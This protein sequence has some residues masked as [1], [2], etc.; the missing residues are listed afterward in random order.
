ML[1]GIPAWALATGAGFYMTKQFFFVAGF[2]ENMQN[3]LLREGKKKSS[4]QA[5]SIQVVP[6]SLAGLFSYRNTSLCCVWFCL[7]LVGFF[8]FLL[9][10]NHLQSGIS[11]NPSLPV[12]P[13][14]A[15]KSL[16]QKATGQQ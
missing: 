12:S 7:L 6:L 14:T 3:K 11:V 5:F 15:G 10:R 16:V 9:K 1:G 4:E 2:G 8:F 13:S